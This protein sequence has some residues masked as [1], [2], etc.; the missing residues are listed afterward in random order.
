MLIDFSTH[1]RDACDAVANCELGRAMK[2]VREILDGRD[3]LTWRQRLQLARMLHIS[4]ILGEAA[5][6]FESV[7]WEHPLDMYDTGRAGDCFIRQGMPQEA[8]KYFFTLL[9]YQPANELGLNGIGMCT[10]QMGLLECG[11]I[12]YQRLLAMNPKSATG[13]NN[14]ALALRSECGHSKAIKHMLSLI[15]N[16]QDHAGIYKNITNLL[17]YVPDVPVDVIDGMHQ[18]WYRVHRCRQ[19]PVP[20]V[21]DLAPE[22][23]LRIGIVS[24]DFRNH[25]V[26]RNFLPIFNELPRDQFEIICYYQ[27]AVVDEIYREYEKGATRIQNIVPFGDDL[28]ARIIRKDECDVIIY[29]AAHFD[30]NRPMLA[31]YRCAPVQISYL[32]SGRVHI[33][34]MDYLL[35]GRHYAPRSLK[36]RGTERILHMPRF[37]QHD[38][39]PSDTAINAVPA[40]ERGFFTFGAFNNP[41]K[42]NDKVLET[43]RKILEAVPNSVLMFKYRAE[44]SHPHVA[45]RVCRLLDS[46]K[47]RIMFHTEMEGG[48]KHFEKIS[49][50]DMHLDS[51]P[52]PGSTTTF[53]CAWMGVPTLTVGGDTIMSNYGPGINRQFGLPDFI[54]K[55]I[56]EYIAKAVDIAAQ[57]EALTPIRAGLR[58]NVRSTAC[59]SN[60]N[61][62]ARW[63]RVLWRKYCKE[64]GALQHARLEVA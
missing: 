22:R 26:G 52:F 16:E 31:S 55:D 46:V 39:Y 6:L 20:L 48:I 4:A 17:Y 28:A 35:V 58:E 32:D 50:V 14:M 47:D 41:V 11:R 5:T 59:V 23:K 42:L 38:Q 43:W 2:L 61:H 51:F 33:P 7:T 37:Y 45:R 1:M 27:N 64:Q 3:F 34:E 18:E 9:A 30:D 36:E 40:L 44:Y 49:Q 62:F 63:C 12:W 60:A 15:D 25:P 8:I 10:M 56:D 21:R 54:A 19:P 53:E 24:S 57:P 29:T 13:L